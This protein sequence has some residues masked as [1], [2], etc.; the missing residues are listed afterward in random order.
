MLVT[1][2]Y[3]IH[4]KGFD[5]LLYEYFGCL[6]SATWMGK[7]IILFSSLYVTKEEAVNDITSKLKVKSLYAVS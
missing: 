5:V 4:I 2:T 6:Y 1:N 3:K 7:D